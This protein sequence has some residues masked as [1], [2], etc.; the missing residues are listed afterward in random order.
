MKLR[1]ENYHTMCFQLFSSLE[2]PVFEEITDISNNR[3]AYVL[4]NGRVMH[5]IRG[6][7]LVGLYKIT[8]RQ[9]IF[10]DSQRSLIRAHFGSAFTF[11]NFVK[12]NI[13]N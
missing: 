8:Q 5:F 1:E 13:Y 12:K 11:F 2:I 9:R 4:S 7:L 10:T 6:K 3:T